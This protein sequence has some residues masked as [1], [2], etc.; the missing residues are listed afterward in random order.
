MDNEGYAATPQFKA[1][2]HVKSDEEWQRMYKAS[3][4]EPEEFW[5]DIARKEFHWETMF[6]KV[7]PV[8]NYNLDK[9]PIHSAWFPGGR[10][11]LS[12]NCLDLQIQRGL[13]KKT[14]FY[15][16]GNDLEDAHRAYSYE[17]LLELVCQLANALKA[18]GIKRGDCVT[19]YLPMIIEGPVA[20]LACTRIG[21]V[22]S[23]VFSG[24]SAEALGSRIAEAASAVVIT[25]DAVMRG[26]KCVQLKAIT[27]EACQIAAKESNFKVSKVICAG[28]LRHSPHSKLAK[29]GWVEG[30]DVWYDDFVRGHAGHC[31]N[32]WIDAEEPLFILYTSGSTGKPKA[33][34]QPLGGY[35]VGE[36]T[37]FKYIF[38][39]HPQDIWFCTSD[40]G[41][42]TGQSSGVVGPLLNGA[43]SVLF[44]GLPNFPGPD[45][46]WQVCAKYKVT[47]FLTAPTAIRSMLKSGE[48]VVRKHD[49]SS[50]RVLGTVGEPINPEAWHWYHRVVGGGR[51]PIVDVY[52]QTETG[53][54]CV[55]PLPGALKMKPGSAGRPFFGVDIGILDDQGKEL[56][57]ECSGTLVLKSPC[58]FMATTIFGDHGR[59]EQ[60]YFSPF[61]GYY[62]T[63]DGCRR[64]RDGDIWFTGR[65]DD[66]INV[67]GHRVGTA[68][69]EGA[70]AGLP[71]VAE[72]AVV[73]F[74][75]E[76][77]GE[78]L[79][80]YVTL[81]AG[82]AYEPRLAEKLKHHV[83]D[84]LG[85]FL[86][87]DVIHWAPELP[88]TRSGKIMRRILRKLAK[89]D[90]MTQ[91]LG[92]ISTLADPSVVDQLKANHPLR[93]GQ[94][95]L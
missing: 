35:M 80:C 72:A 8:Y 4:E 57:G 94:S 37:L 23:V 53:G 31:A 33:L 76:V 47:Q 71:E 79:W 92:D 7:G 38:D 49:L 34:V 93:P 91:D 19:L 82:Y 88:K 54:I 51:C 39:Y 73:G 1:K 48:E 21:A 15:F 13:A 20:L 30:R 89:P 64:D 58:P 10:T 18:A 85:A 28:R 86:I 22:H 56:Q 69:V 9:G 66:V 42:I 67:S 59:F 24:F 11:N 83:R 40:I 16:E 41:W 81:K 14:A 63:G 84:K 5:G 52:G 61:R 70:L 50:L 3:I 74:P 68:Q 65:T 46:F 95:R 12:Y 90:Y 32:E 6:T 87:P 62:W 55:A 75:H 26:G 36:W 27:D 2:S 25:S 17:E 44:E 45:R 43:T 60:T 78:G 29:H 77:K